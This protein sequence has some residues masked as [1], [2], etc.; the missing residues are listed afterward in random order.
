MQ[1]LHWLRIRILDKERLESRITADWIVSWIKPNQ[2]CVHER[3]SREQRHTLGHRVLGISQLGEDQ[4]TRCAEFGI[5]LVVAVGGSCRRWSG[6]RDRSCDPRWSRLNEIP[7]VA[8]EIFEDSHCG[9]RRVLGLA[10]E[11]HAG[12]PHGMVVAPEIVGLE[13]QKDTTSSLMPD[14]RVLLGRGCA[15]QK[16]SSAG[17]IGRSDDYPPLV[18]LGLVSVLQELE[19]ELVAV[20]CNRL[21]VVSY[22]QGYVPQLVSHDCSGAASRGDLSVM[23]CAA[24]GKPCRLTGGPRSPARG[25]LAARPVHSVVRLALLLPGDDVGFRRADDI[26]QLLLLSRRDLECVQGFLE[27]LGHHAPLLFTDV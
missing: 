11:M 20:E 6:G 25:A 1:L 17:G 4:R 23:H 22:D 27:L 10:N 15:R 8:I 13:K 2:V 21:I 3:R 26:K 24:S 9:V 19:L 7:Q 12:R 14:G 16:Q 18:L 5:I